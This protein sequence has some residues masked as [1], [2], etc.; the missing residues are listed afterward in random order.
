MNTWGK[1]WVTKP[2]TATRWRPL[3]WRGRKGIAPA[4]GSARSGSISLGKGQPLSGNLV[5]AAC[6]TFKLYSML[7]ARSHCLLAQYSGLYLG[8][9]M[10]YANFSNGMW[11]SVFLTDFVNFV[12]TPSILN[13]V[14]FDRGSSQPGS[15]LPT[16]R[17]RIAFSEQC[18]R[19]S[20]FP[21]CSM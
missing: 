21:F 13:F 20:A 8:V 14:L 7:P 4:R 9:K 19:C 5:T 12:F 3:S 15:V 16:L 11:N 6:R 18:C 2:R 1:F 10:I 17:L